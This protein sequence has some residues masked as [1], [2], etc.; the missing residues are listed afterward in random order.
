MFHRE[1]KAAQLINLLWV[2]PCPSFPLA[3]GSAKTRD[4]LMVVAQAPRIMCE[5]SSASDIA[6]ER[7]VTRRVASKLDTMMVIPR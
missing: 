3:V 4:S 7:C 2:H 6:K 1:L 5:A